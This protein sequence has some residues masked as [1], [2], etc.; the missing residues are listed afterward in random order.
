MLSV[1]D[2]VHWARCHGSTAVL[3]LRSGQWQMFSGTGARIW[4]AITLHGGTEGLAEEIALPDDLDV[5]ATRTAIDSY[6]TAL[7][8]MGLLVRARPEPR[9][10]RGWRRWRR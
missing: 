9:R 1:P 7:L 4:D 8:S 3:D 5:A 6:V 2:H 10:H